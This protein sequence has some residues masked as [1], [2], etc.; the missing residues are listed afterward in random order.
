MVPILDTQVEMNGRSP[1]LRYV[2]VRGSL[3]GFDFNR[4]QDPVLMQGCELN[5]TDRWSRSYTGISPSSAFRVGASFCRKGGR[6]ALCFFF[7]FFLLATT[8]RRGLIPDSDVA[9]GWSALLVNSKI[10]DFGTGLNLFSR[11]GLANNG[12]SM[13]VDSTTFLRGRT[14][15]SI[16]TGLNFRLP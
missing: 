16:L 11:N 10:Q 2:H 1:V 12:S 6:G 3:E 9:S 13:V 4:V 8:W 14:A 5:G 7:V 15:V